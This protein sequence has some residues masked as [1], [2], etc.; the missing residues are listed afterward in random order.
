MA[1]LNCRDLIQNS[2]CHGST[3]LYG[4]IQNSFCHGNTE[5][6]GSIQKSFCHDSTELYG[7][8]QNSFCHG[9]N[10]LYGSIQNSFCHGSTELYGSIQNSFCHGSTELYG[11]IP[12]SFCHG[13]TEL[14]GSIPNSFWGFVAVGVG[15]WHQFTMLLVTIG[16]G[17]CR[18]G[19]K[20]C[21]CHAVQPRSST[22]SILLA[23]LW[24]GILRDLGYVE[25]LAASLIACA[26][27][28]HIQFH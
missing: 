3:V 9:S 28:M 25:S 14:Y 21:L 8:I 15:R 6:Y 4:S 10:E 23:W 24:P 18:V 11:Y 16:F 13:N 7:S 2:F 26:H 22:F 12:N 1:A 27:S 5:L 19:K 20:K 17:V